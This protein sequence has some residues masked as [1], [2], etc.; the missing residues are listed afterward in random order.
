[1]AD[2]EMA[3]SSHPASAVN[4]PDRVA[5]HGPCGT[6]TSRPTADHQAQA[7]RLRVAMLV[8][9]FPHAD[10]PANCVFNLQAARALSR[11]VDLTVVHLRAWKLGR[12]GLAI[13]EFEGVRVIT[14]T[15]PQL[16]G[17]SNVNIEIYRCLGWLRLRS[18]L[19]SCD[20]IHSVSAE[21]AGILASAWGR[22]ACVPHLTQIIGGDINSILPRRLT[23]RSIA[24]WEK[25]VHAV[26]CNSRALANRF[27]E[28][29]P[30][31]RNVRT[32][33][34]GV[35][36][37]RYHT[38]G[39][40]IGPLAD[41][42]PVRFLFLGGFPPYQDMPHRD[43]TKGGWTLLEAW[44]AAECHLIP[45]G[46]SLLIGGPQSDADCI[47]RWRARLR[48]PN[49]V[50]LVG[51]L[52]PDLVPGYLRSA[53]VV[54]V[55]SLE[56]GLPN[57]AMEASACGRAVFGSDVGG[58]SEV[59]ADGETGRLLPPS[60]VMAWKNALIAYADRIDQLRTM[61]KHARRRMELQFDCRHFAPLMLDLYHT[62]LREPIFMS[63]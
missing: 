41:R 49:R 44:K 52:H 16:P 45:T 4:A 59:I 1:M 19:R 10:R 9:G 11:S 40:V 31:V 60:D 18:L 42:P 5:C 33:Y 63:Q 12:P 47:I 20:L 23:C 56:E 24:G 3:A 8:I 51:L 58:I 62:A 22:W 32:I 26:A 54:L 2:D 35:D 43:N 25:H 46:A 13:S 7:R 17:C 21:F 29:Y 6:A 61:G 15:A 14:V 37:Q 28:L 30:Q 39:P 53:E 36:L 27:L 48:N 50:H 38:L 55:P 57:L 34:R